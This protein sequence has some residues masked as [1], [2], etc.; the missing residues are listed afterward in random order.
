MAVHI[1]KDGSN[2]LCGKVYKNGTLDKTDL[3]LNEITCKKCLKIYD[4][5]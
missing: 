2:P 4:K 5:S 1:S 3:N